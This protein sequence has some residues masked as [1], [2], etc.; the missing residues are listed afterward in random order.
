[1]ARARELLHEGDPEGGCDR[2]CYDCLLSFYNQRYHELLNRALVLPVLQALEE[3]EIEPIPE[4]STGPSFDELDARCQSG[5]E[6]QVL[7]AICDRGLPLPDAAQKTVYDG[8]APIATADFFYAP[9]ILV[10]VDGSP[11]YRDYVAAAD[12]RKRRRLKA[13]GYRILAIT[14]DGLE[15]ALSRLKEWLGLGAA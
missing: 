6:R 4:M 12:Q 2:A 9:R 1:V 8:D 13:L 3:L 11:H 14:G 15:E 7:A 10:F 5:L